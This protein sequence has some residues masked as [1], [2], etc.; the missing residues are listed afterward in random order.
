MV[1][2]CSLPAFDGFGECRK[3]P[4]Y[5]KQHHEDQGAPPDKSIRH[6]IG[7]VRF[8]FLAQDKISSEQSSNKKQRVQSY[9]A[10]DLTV[11][12]RMQCP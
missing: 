7:P 10:A 8:E 4:H 1:L 3:I 2:Q 12:Q 6:G 5:P 11:Q 9:S